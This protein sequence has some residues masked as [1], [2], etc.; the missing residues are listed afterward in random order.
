VPRPWVG[1]F[2]RGFMGLLL[3]IGLFLPD[4]TA[5]IAEIYLGFFFLANG[6]FSLKMVKQIKTQE[7]LAT[8][9][10]IV[11]VIG[12]IIVTLLKLIS[13]IIDAVD[14]GRVLF[15]PLVIIIG[16]FQ[17]M[18]LV[19]VTPELD[20]RQIRSNFWL[21]ILEILLGIAILIYPPIDWQVKI[22]AHAWII[23][24]TF[25]M[26]TTAFR[27]RK[28]GAQHQVGSSPN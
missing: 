17:I 2:V 28:L 4:T 27:L 12:G 6:M 16:L 22:I 20:R 15:A 1:F 14:V 24:V 11:S 3:S 9:G 13:P 25:Y 8:V 10:A 21:G 7:R 5:K 26:L 18:G 19:R 23:I